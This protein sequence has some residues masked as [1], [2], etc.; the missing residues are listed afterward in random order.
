MFLLHFHEHGSNL[1]VLEKTEQLHGIEKRIGMVSDQSTNI[2]ER[3][4]VK[5]A[6]KKKNDRL[7]IEIM[8]HLHGKHT[9]VKKLNSCHKRDRETLVLN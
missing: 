5:G 6:K 4:R 3:C 7:P 9:E 8:E 1:L 2:V